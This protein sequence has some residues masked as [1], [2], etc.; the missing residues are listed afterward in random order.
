MC[1]T[2]TTWLLFP[3]WMREQCVIIALG[4]L[5]IFQRDRISALYVTKDV[6]SALYACVVFFGD[7]GR[8]RA[9]DCFTVLWGKC[10]NEEPL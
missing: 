4:A 2:W 6:Q 8:F 7:N 5:G 10:S 9:G 1:I 3:F